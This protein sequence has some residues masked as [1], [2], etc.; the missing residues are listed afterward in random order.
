MSFN[1]DS[2]AAQ[3]EKQY[4]ADKVKLAISYMRQ[5]RNAQAF[6]ILSDSDTDKD[7][8]ARFALGL[9]YLRSGD[10]PSAITRFDQALN[11]LKST[12]AAKREI[13]SSTDAYYNLAK[14][15]VAE[16]VYLAPMDADFCTIFPEAAEQTVILALT[17]A[18]L[19]NGMDE[20]ARRISAGLVGPMF[21]EYKRTLM[22]L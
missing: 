6:L 17:Y 5:G 19:K 9:C 18:Y 15:Q 4:G 16:N 7:P 20:Q 1:T 21:D 22:K 12:S 13:K 10:V 11:I 2:P 8:A 14:N 3:G